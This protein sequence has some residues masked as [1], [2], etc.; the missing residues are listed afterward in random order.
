M[1][2]CQALVVDRGGCEARDERSGNA[3][4]T[5]LCDLQPVAV[6]DRHTTAQQA[7]GRWLPLPVRGRSQGR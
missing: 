2:M 3:A 5:M 4:L 6:P 1:P 7:L